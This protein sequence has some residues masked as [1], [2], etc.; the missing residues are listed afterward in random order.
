MNF[1]FFL[2]FNRKWHH[3]V[4]LGFSAI[5]HWHRKNPRFEE[6]GMVKAKQTTKQRNYLLNGSRI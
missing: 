1:S 6:N 3:C 5:R 2:H 4:A